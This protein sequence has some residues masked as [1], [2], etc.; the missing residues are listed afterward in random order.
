MTN[1]S[2]YTQSGAQLKKIPNTSERKK[3]DTLEDA[4]RF[5]T[6]WLTMK[7]KLNRSGKSRLEINPDLQIIVMEYTN[8][9]N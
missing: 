9:Y 7:S 1:Y 5:G 6:G 2:L 4:V 8:P 3:F